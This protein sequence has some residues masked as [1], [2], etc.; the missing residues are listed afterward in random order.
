MARYTNDQFEGPEVQSAVGTRVY[1]APEV[2]QG[3]Y[4]LKADLWSIGVILL[5]MLITNIPWKNKTKF[6]NKDQ[7]MTSFTT[8]KV[9]LEDFGFQFSNICMNM[10]GLLLQRDPQRRIDIAQ[11]KKH[12]FVESTPRVYEDLYKNYIPKRE[13]DVEAQP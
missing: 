7:F 5:D 10:L 4:D 1:M 9:S 3:S 8:G 12:P 2:G 11:L 13:G 6:Q